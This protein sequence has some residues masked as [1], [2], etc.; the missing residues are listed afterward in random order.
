MLTLKGSTGKDV[1]WY[2]FNTEKS[3]LYIIISHFPKI[4]LVLF[5][6]ILTCI[7]IA[8]SGKPLSIFVQDSEGSSPAT[9]IEAKLDDL[10]YKIYR[11]KGRSL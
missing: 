6:N 11:G 7:S 4:Y 3:N 5:D 8:V 2:S 9:P 10:W 1:T